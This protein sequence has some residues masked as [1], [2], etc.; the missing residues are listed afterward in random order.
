[1]KPSYD[2]YLSKNNSVM[3]AKGA[4]FFRTT[5]EISLESKCKDSS[6]SEIF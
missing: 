4:S 6:A 1:M 3:F 2:I 5:D